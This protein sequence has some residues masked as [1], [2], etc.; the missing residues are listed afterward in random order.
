MEL[1]SNTIH[2]LAM[3][4]GFGIIFFSDIFPR[5]AQ[6]FIKIAGFIVVFAPLGLEFVMPLYTAENTCYRCIIENNGAEFYGYED[7]TSKETEDTKSNPPI[8]TR[9]IH[10]K[11]P[12][13]MDGADEKYATYYGKFSTFQLQSDKGPIQKRVRAAQ[14]YVELLGSVFRH[15][16]VVTLV[17][18]DVVTS[19][20]EE[21]MGERLPTFKIKRIIQGDYEQNI[22]EGK[23]EMIVVQDSPRLTAYIRK[24]KAEIGKL[25]T[26]I[27]Q[28]RVRFGNANAE[29][30]Q[31]GLR[32]D[33]AKA[34]ESGL[35][36]DQTNARIEGRIYAAHINRQERDWEKTSRRLSEQKWPKWIMPSI[37]ALVG[38]A[39]IFGI[40]YANP[41]TTL[42]FTNWLGQAQNQAFL[43]IILAII[44]IIVYFLSKRLKQ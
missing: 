35:V 34:T 19:G 14:R 6:G 30:L 41:T 5:E 7:G 18:E 24:L 31:S 21:Y 33:S 1:S 8:Y 20:S 44:A 43:I 17:V 10:S 42:G 37:I 9:S 12:C 40:I 29:R 23:A 13:E 38:I 15:R 39:I 36:K 32:L 26:V 11:W 3:A 27:G 22:E 2:F 16:A 4:I 25:N 28:Y